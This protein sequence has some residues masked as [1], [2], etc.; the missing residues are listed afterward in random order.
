MENLLPAL[1]PDSLSA[2]DVFGAM[3]EIALRSEAVHAAATG[4]GGAVLQLVALAVAL[5]YI[6]T[7]VRYSDVVMAILLSTVGVTPSKRGGQRYYNFALLRNVEIV[8]ALSGIVAAAVVAVRIIGSP[9]T[10][11]SLPTGAPAYACMAV[12]GIA[13]LVLSEYSAVRI[14]GSVSG[15]KDVCASILQIKLRHFSAAVAFVLPTGMLFIFAAPNVAGACFYIMAAQC[16]ISAILF[17]KETFSLFIA[18][19][20]SILYWI[21]YLCTLEVFPVSVLLAPVMRAGSGI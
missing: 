10:Q 8:V 14:V 19:R 1:P 21:L 20:V 11:V 5:L 18:E 9:T 12:A 7:V 17:A 6:Y 16:F 3:S 13:A 15:R 2:A 4:A